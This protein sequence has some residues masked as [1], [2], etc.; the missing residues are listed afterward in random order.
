MR[1]SDQ[2]HRTGIFLPAPR[3]DLCLDFAN[4]IA[5]RGSTPEESL[6]G[7]NE[8]L[9]WCVKAGTISERSAREYASSANKHSGLDQFFREAI[10]IR[11]ALYRIFF[12]TASATT[13]ADGDLRLLNDSLQRA[14]MRTTVE[15]GVTGFG[16]QVERMQP[17]V[18]AMLAPVLWSAA[19]LLVGPGLARVRHCANDRCLWLFIDDSKNG[20][21]RWCSMQSCGNRAKAHR[22]YLR[23]KHK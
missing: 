10:A 11:E 2:R 7:F 20:T 13:P 19:D 17:S 15:R 8:L 21:R 4:T 1:S 18:P 9:D 14:P 5:W 22:H 6:A 12:E 16:W 3:I 23:Q